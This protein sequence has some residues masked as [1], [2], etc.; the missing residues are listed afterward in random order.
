MNIEETALLEQKYRDATPEEIIKA[1]VELFGDS[2]ALAT[3]LAFED[4]AVTYLI[5]QETKNIEIFTLDTGRLFQET[6]DTIEQTNQF[7][8]IQIR[9]MFPDQSEVESMVNR[10]G[11]NLFYEGV[12]NRKECCNIRKTLPMQ[13]A[14][15]GKKAWITGLRREQSV[16]RYGLKKIEFDEKN[17]IVKLN[18]IADWTEKQT[19]DFVRQHQI[20]FNKLQE[21]GFRSIGCMPCTRAVSAGEDIRA[22][23]W[24]WETPEHKECGLHK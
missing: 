23:R 19:I 5:L 8:N 21:H 10:K 7:F 16:T 14:L 4:Q 6:Y 3:S 15:S 17:N 12:D 9:I 20:P 18:P 22:G 1:A 11:I 24:W 2:L 13:R